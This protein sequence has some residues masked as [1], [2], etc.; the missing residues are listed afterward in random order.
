MFVVERRVRTKSLICHEPMR[1]GD[2]KCDLIRSGIILSFPSIGRKLR[3]IF[4]PS[5]IRPV[6]PDDR[7]ILS[8]T[9]HDTA[10]PLYLRL[11][12]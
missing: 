7:R 12:C 11:A 3:I 4:D 8:E 5:I 9:F 6:L 1:S 2:S 10:E